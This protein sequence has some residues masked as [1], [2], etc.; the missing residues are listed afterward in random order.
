MD[1]FLCFFWSQLQAISHFTFSI[2]SESEKPTGWEGTGEGTVR[3]EKIDERTLLMHEEGT[4]K[5]KGFP[6]IHFT[7]L[8]K[9]TL[10]DHSIALEHL[11]FGANQPV[12]LVEF[13]LETPLKLVSKSPHV[14]GQDVYKAT[15]VWKTPSL[16]LHWSIQGPYKNEQIQYTY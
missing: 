15:L 11:R 5:T 4:R 12:F 1:S 8:S 16:I 10:R 7:N 2:H 14:C 3:I 6:N 9:W 13:T